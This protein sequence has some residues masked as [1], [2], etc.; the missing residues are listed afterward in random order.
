M[1]TTSVAPAGLYFIAHTKTACPLVFPLTPRFPHT[2][3]CSLLIE[4]TRERQSATICNTKSKP[5]CCNQ[6]SKSQMKNKMQRYS[7][8]LEGHSASLCCISLLQNSLGSLPL[9][10]LFISESPLSRQSVIVFLRY[11]IKLLKQLKAHLL[12]ASLCCLNVNAN[13]TNAGRVSACAAALCTTFAAEACLLSIFKSLKN[14]VVCSCLSYFC[15][16]KHS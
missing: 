2:H 12:A 11:V 16:R 4:R 6:Q 13:S 3:I 5:S 7:C 15:S 14:A 9:S 1:N 8:L 10:W